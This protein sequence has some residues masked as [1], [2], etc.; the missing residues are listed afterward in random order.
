MSA[1][2]VQVC[3][4]DLEKIEEPEIKLTASTRLFKKAKELQK[5]ICFTDYAKALTLWMTTKW[6]NFKEMGIPGHVT[7]LLRNLY[8][9][10]EAKIDP[11]MDQWTGST[12]GKDYIKAV[13]CRPAYLTSM[14]STSCQMPGSVK[15]K[16]ESRLLE[17]ISII[18]DMQMIPP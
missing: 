14:Q 11:G 5:N 3:K 8:T 15:L 13:Y 12:L 7:C 9:G 10:Q 4:L 16:L 2:N 1:D 18:S 17:E 6:K